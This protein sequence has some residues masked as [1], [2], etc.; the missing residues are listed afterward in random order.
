MGAA[1]DRIGSERAL[2]IATI[3]EGTMIIGITSSSRPWM[4]YLF[5]GILGFGYGGH[6]PQLPGLTG[7]LFGLRRMGTILGTAA[8]LYGVGGAFGPFLA[9]HLFDRS[10]SY[11]YAFPLG[12]T[13]MFLA[14]A[15]TFFLKRPKV[16]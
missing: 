3:I 13:V 11:I 8:V 1:S 7:K 16:E 2:A 10:G 4:L 15:S 14:A 9:G 6:V 12:A 5:A